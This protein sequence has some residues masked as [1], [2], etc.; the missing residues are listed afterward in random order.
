MVNMRKFAC[1]ASG[2][3]Q[4]SAT[5]HWRLELP[6]VAVA[7]VTQAMAF[8]VTHH[9]ITIY[10]PRAHQPR[11][12]QYSR[13]AN[14]THQILLSPPFLNLNRLLKSIQTAQLSWT[15]ISLLSVATRHRG[16]VE[17]GNSHSITTRWLHHLCVKSFWVIFEHTII[18]AA[19]VCCE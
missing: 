3:P 1:G 9:V 5:Q 2:D 6:F 7:V 17:V 18:T 12:H 16:G 8:L 11:H 10:Q 13:R 4:K 19:F 14:Y 15:W